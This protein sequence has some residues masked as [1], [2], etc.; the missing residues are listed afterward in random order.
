[1][2][3]I[4]FKFSN[5]MDSV[6]QVRSGIYSKPSRDSIQKSKNIFR[7]SKPR[8]TRFSSLGDVLNVIKDAGREGLIISIISRRANLVHNIALEKCHKLT[9]AGLIEEKTEDNKKTYSITEKGLD[10][11]IEYGK[12]QSLVEP[13]RLK[14]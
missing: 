8:R 4:Y 12:F 13:L 1:M 3:I 5:F 10:F 6:N 11:I 14:F 7:S 9:S 2:V